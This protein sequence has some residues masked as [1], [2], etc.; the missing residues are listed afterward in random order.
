MTKAA[1]GPV[2]LPVSRHDIFD[3]PQELGWW[4]QETPIRR[5]TY[6]DG[7]LG[8]LVTGYSAVRAVLADNRFS[9][10][11]DLQHPPTPHIARQRQLTVPAGFF[12]RMDPPDHTRFRR[13]LTGQ[14]TVRRMKQLEPRIEKIVA[15]RLDEMQRQG[16]PADL[17]RSF[18]LPIPS[19]VICELLGV[20]Y[21]DHDRFQRDSAVIISREETVERKQT[22]MADLLSYL[23]ELVLRKRA[24]PTDDLLGGLVADGELTDEELTGV[25]TLLLV[26]GHE[27]TANMIAL[28]TFALLSNPPQLAALR[29]D[30]SLTAGAVEEFMRY[31]TIIDFTA[32]T[33]LEDV[34]IEGQTIRAGETVTLSLPAANRDPSR[35]DGADTLDVTRQ[36]AGHLSFGH[37][38]HQCLGQ[39]LA[40]NEMRI[41][42][43][44]LLERLPGLRLAVPPEEVPMRSDMAIYGVHR[45][46]V[47][48]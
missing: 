40:R 35:F 24:E 38:V 4:R 42:L 22:A 5:M 46:P 10:R 31:L 26:A 36:A 2:T 27:T 14:F 6:A 23:H 13:L 47:T 17:V 44:A 18:A 20:P 34:E 21:T 9:T 16:P 30:P 29:D 32:R 8:W 28:S 19:L 48:W 39:Q 33:A 15:D 3:P 11:I 45:L 25:A 12:L 37:G 41:A 43:P 1:S 7:H